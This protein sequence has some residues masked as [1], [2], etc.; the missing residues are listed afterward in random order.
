[1]SRDQQQYDMVNW[2][3]WVED[4]FRKIRKGITPV[5]V[6]GIQRLPNGDLE[7]QGGASFGPGGSKITEPTEVPAP[8]GLVLS[9]DSS[10]DTI[11]IDASWSP[12]GGY[13]AEQ[14]AKY[15]VQAYK[16]GE[17]VPW[18]QIITGNSVRIEPVE[19]NEYYTVRV[20]SLTRT[21]RASDIIEDVILTEGDD[22]EPASPSFPTPAVLP[23]ILALSVRW[24]ANTERDVANGKGTYRVVVSPNA[25]LSAPVFDERQSGT[26]QWADNLEP[27]TPYYVGVAAIDSS[28]NESDF[29]IPPGGP[30]EA[31]SN[32]TD[33]SAFAFG[34]GN[35][36]KN[37]GFEDGTTHWA[38]SG[39]R[40]ITT[41]IN[42]VSSQY[43]GP[44]GTKSLEISGTGDFYGYTDI[45]LTKGTYV[46]SGWV[47]AQ[48]I[49][50]SSG[51]PLGVCLNSEMVSGARTDLQII[52]GTSPGNPNIV[53]A[54]MGTYDWTRLAIR[55]RVISAGTM[56]VYCQR[57]GTGA[58]TGSAWFDDVQVEMGDVL[59]GYAPRPDEILSNTI[60]A[61]M[62]ADNQITTPKLAA[63]SVVAGK[64]AAN[65][66]GA[67]EIQAASITGGKIAADTI[68]GTNIAAS[69]I[70]ADEIATNAVTADKIIANAV[71]AAKL[72][73]D[74]VTADKL[75][76]MAISV[77]KFIQSSSY[78]ANSSGWIIHGNGSAEFNNVTVRGTLN[79]ARFGSD[80]FD[81]QRPGGDIGVR[82]QF[83][84]TEDRLYLGEGAVNAGQYISYDNLDGQMRFA[85]GNWRFNTRTIF[86]S[87]IIAYA[88]YGCGYW[89]SGAGYF[90]AG[91][92]GGTVYDSNWGV[93][94]GTDGGAAFTAMLQGYLNS[95]SRHVGLANMNGGIQQVYIDCTDSNPANTRSLTRTGWVVYSDPKGKSNIRPLG[96]TMKSA[97]EK[98]NAIEPIRYKL[99]QKAGKKQIRVSTRDHLSFD[100]EA[101]REIVPEAVH[102]N[103]CFVDPE[104]AT[105]DDIAIGIQ[106]DVLIPVLWQGHR[107]QDEEIAELRELV[108]KLEIEIN[109][110]KQKAS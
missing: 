18:S 106:P 3:G 26:V 79:S 27:D 6:A 104:N 30:W 41:Q 28:G 82:F 94:F 11:W 110:L 21:D 89:G 36:V 93:G 71:T 81:F 39:D 2:M 56:R 76:A 85:N 46:L 100:A 64:I 55:F 22:T 19:P 1:M 75:A 61:T 10:F 43:H 99:R 87:V 102:E 70:T 78:V 47:R 65:A 68:T 54:G 107:E 57:G 83:T 34:G 101:L 80:L 98:I 62:I 35:V 74:S 73:A 24:N 49:A 86:D 92:P 84:G 53:T 23:G 45:P 14:V 91:N 4:E 12:P 38:F 109:D 88:G 9:S 17:V 13:G 95:T 52:Y 20:A 33:T 96:Q 37:S 72:A 8:S 29:A 69:T 50:A 7:F 105:D 44:F 32:I 31:L 108:R 15:L 90:I 40:A 51:T 25:D 63:A 5:S 77:G 58:V 59:T 48:D 103:V 60:Q 67:N 42:V 97:R 66:I 16:D